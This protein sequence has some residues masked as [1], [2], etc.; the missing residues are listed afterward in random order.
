MKTVPGLEGRGNYSRGEGK[1]ICWNKWPAT[2][3]ENLIITYRMEMR[4]SC[5]TVT[6]YATNASDVAP[7][8]GEI[9]CKAQVYQEEEIELRKGRLAN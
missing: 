5:I 9:H 1:Q 7:W 3:T 4:K 6:V 8:T 2:L